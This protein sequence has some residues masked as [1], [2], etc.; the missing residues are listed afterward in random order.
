MREPRESREPDET[1]RDPALGRVAPRWSAARG[2]HNLVAIHARIKRAPRRGH[3]LTLALAGAGLCAG[4]VA[5]AAVMRMRVRTAEVAPAVATAR[6]AERRSVASRR[7]E[8]AAIDP[9]PV[10]ETTVVPTHATR[11]A[12]TAVD[13]PPTRVVP[14]AVDAPDVE[15]LMRSADAARRAG[16]PAQALP[17]LRRLLRDHPA[18]A[19]APLAAFTLGRILL[20]ELGRPAEAADAFALSRRLAPAGPMASHALAREVEAAARGGDAA[21]ARRLAETY[22]ADYPAGPHLAAVRRHG[23]IE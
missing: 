12:P 8:P 6:R 15:A 22:I 14:T 16:H 9:S 4:T 20:A 3:A 11:V 10:A 21:R 18:D 1:A 17:Y 5:V 7:A 13:A 23:G 19:R 2:R